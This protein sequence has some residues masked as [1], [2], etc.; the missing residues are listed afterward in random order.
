MS[1]QHATNLATIS[2]ESVNE[3]LHL[4]QHI[5]SLL[6]SVQSHALI[7]LAAAVSDFYIP[8]EHLAQHK[9]QSS[10]GLTLDLHQVPKTLH[11]LTSTWAP[12][13]YVVS[14]KLETDANIL[15]SKAQAAIANY[16]V[17]MV[18]ANILQV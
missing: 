7:Y 10:S 9:I 6:S 3:Y 5:T 17:H 4:L 14:F 11:L 15:I 13:A 16:H 18:V 8:E 1:Q 12:Q 2:F